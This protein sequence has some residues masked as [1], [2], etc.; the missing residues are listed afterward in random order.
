MVMD[1]TYFKFKGT[2]VSVTVDSP[3]DSITINLFLTPSATREF[4][5][6]CKDNETA[7]QI[8]NLLKGRIMMAK[9]TIC[10]DTSEVDKLS[11]ELLHS[12]RLYYDGG[13]SILASDPVSEIP[14]PCADI[15]IPVM[16]TNR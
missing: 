2:L 9:V 16:L 10:I 4:T 7:E 6:K 15:T 11:H 14:N 1:N 8:F 13:I 3:G 12:L 5:F